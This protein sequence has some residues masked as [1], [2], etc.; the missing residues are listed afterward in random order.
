MRINGRRA[1][2]AHFA[3]KL[4]E[5]YLRCKSI[6]A[7]TDKKG[8]A[9]IDIGCIPSS[10][11]QYEI[12]L[13]G[14]S[15]QTIFGT[16]KISFVCGESVFFVRETI[17]GSN[18]FRV[19]DGRPGEN[20]Y[21]IG[22]HYLYNVVTVKTV[23]NGTPVPFESTENL[24]LIKGFTECKISYF[25]VKDGG[26]FIRDMYPAKEEATG[27]YGLWDKVERKFY[28]SANGYKIIGYE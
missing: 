27:L 28:T 5:G 22:N 6:A 10:S 25:S 19:W 3:G 16:D 24:F 4:A 17:N 14:L 1:L 18:V 8:Y 13:E 21:I 23:V 2:M 26:H 9:T 11:A 12:I 7:Q 20:H 15:N